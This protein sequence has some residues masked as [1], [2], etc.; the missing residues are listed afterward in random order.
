MYRCKFP[1]ESIISV[2]LVARNRISKLEHVLC[3]KIVGAV[4][5]YP[6][7]LGTYAFF[8]TDQCH[9]YVTEFLDSVDLAKV[10]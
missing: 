2:K 9:V 10:I 4:V 3:G 8:T 1:D 6:L 7:I 5:I